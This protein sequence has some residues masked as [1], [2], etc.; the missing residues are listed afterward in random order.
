MSKLLILDKDWTLVKPISGGTFVQHPE[1][2]ELLPGVADT[3]AHYHAEGWEMVIA[4]N[5]GG[6]TAGH[7]TLDDAIAE[8]RY[9]MRLLPQ[10]AFS[11]FC[12][13]QGSDCW[14]V[15]SAREINVLKVW[16]KFNAFDDLVGKF[17]KPDA[18]MLLLS[19]YYHFWTPERGGTLQPSNTLFVGDMDT[20][21]QCA[22]NA[23]VEFIWASDW[24][25]QFAE[26]A[27]G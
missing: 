13:D 16:K 19:Q 17:R 4:S 11:L 9:C 23:G 24:V 3:I 14:F 21:F 6:V 15:G 20:D 7:K 26:I 5:Q 27:N 1:D 2:Q 8:M 12:P 10:I 25:R 18:G 22:Q